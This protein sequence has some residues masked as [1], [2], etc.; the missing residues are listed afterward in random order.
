MALNQQSLN[1]TYQW[2]N[3]I[4]KKWGSVTAPNRFS[5]LFLLSCSV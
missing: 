2:H 5:A 3:F 1:P 4:D